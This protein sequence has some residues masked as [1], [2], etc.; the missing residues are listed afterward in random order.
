MR[1]GCES[2]GSTVGSSGCWL[3]SEMGG[4]VIAG[5]LPTMYI[6]YTGVVDMRETGESITGTYG[7][8]AENI[9]HLDIGRLVPDAGPGRGR[10]SN[11]SE[12]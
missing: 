3:L 5:G 12:D 2:C 7:V 8:F 9:T 1:E 4:C 6:I 10:E 11:D